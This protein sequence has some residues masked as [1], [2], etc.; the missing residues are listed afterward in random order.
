MSDAIDALKEQHA[1]VTALF[2]QIDK[3]ADPVLRAQI[4]RTLDAHLRTHAV[5]EE[6]IFYPAFRERA[7]SKQQA[8][9]VNEALH[10]HDRMKTEL[11][12]IERTDPSSGE[13]KTRLAS[14]KA[15]VV[16]HVLEEETGML[17]QA[18]KLFTTTELEAMGLH[19]T[20]YAAVASPVY[21]MAGPAV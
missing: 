9:E 17:K 20:Q 8:G 10:E 6:H 1:E 4:F 3:A 5:L 19:M 18:R 2:M 21:E 12:N 7:R 14:L 16:E 11:A 13:F 15:L